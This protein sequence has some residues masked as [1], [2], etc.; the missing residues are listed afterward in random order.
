MNKERLSAF[1][2]A[3]IA[4]LVTIMVL[5]FE[6]PEHATWHDLLSENWAYFLAYLVAFVDVGVSWYN[7]HYLFA[8]SKRITRK[9]Y[10]SNLF[11]MFTL[12]LIPFSIKFLGSHMM[13]VV[14][15]IFYFIVNFSWGISYKILTGNLAKANP[16]VSD[17][18]RAMPVYRFINS[19][20]W[21]GLQL[22]SLAVTIFLFPP[23]V[24]II[25]GIEIGVAALVSDNPEV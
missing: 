2:D 18:L 20:I 13:S 10:F 19:P 3:I 22:F 23:F 6:V 15:A 1:S 11:W 8:I 4:I 14:P 25:N 24:L 5:E 16:D 12:S 21:W 7:H 9:I 17:R